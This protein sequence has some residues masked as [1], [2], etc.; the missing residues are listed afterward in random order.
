MFQHKKSPALILLVC[1]PQEFRVHD[2]V[3]KFIVVNPRRMRESV[4]A[5]CLSVRL[6]PATSFHV[7]WTDCSDLIV[8]LS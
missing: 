1:V 2:Y 4:T 6:T 7:Y 3:L 5:V 8:S